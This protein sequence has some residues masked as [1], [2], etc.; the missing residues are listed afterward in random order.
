MNPLDSILGT[1]VAG[2]V[3]AGVLMFVVSKLPLTVVGG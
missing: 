3:L 1:I 2:F